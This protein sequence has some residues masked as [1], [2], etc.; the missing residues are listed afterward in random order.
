MSYLVVIQKA[1]ELVILWKSNMKLQITSAKSASVFLTTLDSFFIL[2]RVSFIL[3]SRVIASSTYM[4]LMSTNILE[5]YK[6]QFLINQG[7]NEENIFYYKI[8]ILYRTANKLPKPWI[9]FFL[10]K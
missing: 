1:P 6:H 8:E 4:A 9:L 10:M 2:G 3:V 7:I 5:G